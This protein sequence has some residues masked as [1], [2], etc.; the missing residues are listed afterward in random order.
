M[1]ALEITAYGGW[2]SKPGDQDRVT[3]AAMVGRSGKN[4]HGAI[5][6]FLRTSKKAAAGQE[7]DRK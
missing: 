2:E 7:V 5:D 1:G 6:A 4:F 3:V